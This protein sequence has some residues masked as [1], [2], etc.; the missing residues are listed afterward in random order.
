MVSKGIK[1]GNDVLVLEGLQ[2]LDFS[3]RVVRLG[4]GR[5][6]DNLEGFAAGR[7]VDRGGDAIG[8]ED[9]VGVAADGDAWARRD[10]W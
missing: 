6:R 5:G 4:S 8:E 1:Q 3:L 7:A 9:A 2:D 10:I